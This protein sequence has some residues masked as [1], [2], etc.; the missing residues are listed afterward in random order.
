MKSG[1]YANKSQGQPLSS[2]SPISLWVS[3]T[4]VNWV[5]R[6]ALTIAALFI[7]VVSVAASPCSSPQGKDTTRSGKAERASKAARTTKDG[8]KPCDDTV[9]DQS[10]TAQ[11]VG[12]DPHFLLGLHHAE[13]GFGFLLSWLASLYS[14]ISLGKAN[15]NAETRFGAATPISGILR[16][17]P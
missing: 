6:T 13:R 7:V 14:D 8:S 16:G 17:A 12:W 4:D 5:Y 15:Q 9:S 3:N 1:F 2:Q 11:E 10:Q